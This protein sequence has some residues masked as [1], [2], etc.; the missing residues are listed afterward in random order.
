M[1][2]LIYFMN[3]SLDGYLSDENGNF[4]W[5]EPKEDV[6][7]YINDIEVKNDILLY[8]RRMYEILAAWECVF[9]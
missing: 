2:K 1:G 3:I 4:D 8:R 5:A 7:R 9:R 6:H